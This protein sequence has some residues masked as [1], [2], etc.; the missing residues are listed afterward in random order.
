V[1][2]PAA[3]KYLVNKCKVVPEM[4]GPGYIL[5]LVSGAHGEKDIDAVEKAFRDLSERFAKHPDQSLG[6]REAAATVSK[7][8]EVPKPTRVMSLREAFLSKARPLP[9][10]EAL[11]K[12]SADTVVIYPP[13]SPIVTPG[14]RIDQ[15]VVEYI[16]HAR[17]AGLN[18]LGRGVHGTEG[19]LKVF[20]VDRS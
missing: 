8:R 7:A 5:L 12:I 16:L 10:E 2:G 15:E 3:V 1:G 4:T 13:G 11:G 20:C 19:E 18:L 14:E 6:C 9:I 17:K